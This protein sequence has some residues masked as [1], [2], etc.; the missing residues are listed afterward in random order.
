MH[1][2]RSNLSADEGE[3]IN[4]DK[5]EAGD[6]VLK[7][8]GTWVRVLSVKHV[9]GEAAV[10][11]FEVERN[12]DY[13]VGSSGVLVHNQT[14]CGIARITPGS[15]PAEEEAAAVMNTLGHIDAGTQP[16]GA[17]SR[18]W[19]STF[20]NNGGDLPGVAGQGGYSE[21]R[22]APAPSTTGAGVRRIVQSTNDGS[23]FYTWTHYGDAGAPAFTRIR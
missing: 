4:S 23:L 7:P 19:G 12:H 18:R 5:L 11:N 16:T 10:Y 15:L 21:F 6:L 9:E 20:W 14:T 17:L 8:D 22:V 13:F 3:W 2:A 1:R